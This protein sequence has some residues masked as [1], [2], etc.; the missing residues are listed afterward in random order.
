M[1]INRRPYLFTGLLFL[2]V[3]LPA[4]SLETAEGKEYIRAGIHI[5]PPFTMT[6]DG[7]NYYGMAV[8]LWRIIE[9]S[10]GLSTA[11]IPYRTVEELIQSA[12]RGDIDIILTNLTVTHQRAQM[13]T[14]TYPWFDGGLRIMVGAGNINSLWEEF[15]RNGQLPAYMALFGLFAAVALVLT[16]ARRRFDTEFPRS[17]TEGFFCNLYEVIV[18]SR[19]GR[20]QRNFGWLGYALCSIWMIFGMAMLAYI[21]STV[22]SSM[23]TVSLSKENI[24]SPAELREKNVG[25]LAGSA[26]EQYLA[27]MGIF[28]VP[29]AVIDDAGNALIEKRVHAVVSDAPVLEYWVYRNPESKTKVVGELFRQEKYAFAAG[30]E[31]DFIEQVSLE[32]ISLYEQG[33]IAELKRKYFGNLL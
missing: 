24:S 28:T 14:F 15:K 8:E 20:L 6:D 27:E 2:V 12:Q 19:S 23:T 32:L 18:I 16:V 22:T 30:K 7:Q 25:T 26:A 3:I 5:S 33:R 10:M 29:F 17:W 4:F 11:Y 9:K 1:T 31:S 13:L 21:T